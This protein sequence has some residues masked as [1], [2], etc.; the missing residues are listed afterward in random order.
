MLASNPG[1]PVIDMLERMGVV[2]QAAQTGAL[3]HPAHSR[4]D[5]GDL[6]HPTPS[7]HGVP[8]VNE[9]L[10]GR[11]I[12]QRRLPQRNDQRFRQGAALNPPDFRTFY[13][14]GAAGYTDYPAL[15]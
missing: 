10:H 9:R 4:L 13:T 7:L 15:G 2:D 11:D 12:D 8:Q 1:E 3:E 6:Q 14:P 5:T